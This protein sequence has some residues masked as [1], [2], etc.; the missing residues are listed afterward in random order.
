[1]P[2]LDLV[3]RPRTQTKQANRLHALAASFLFHGLMLALILSLRVLY[4][5]TAPPIK[6]GSMPGAPSITLEKMVVISP[7]PQPPAPMVVTAQSAP[8]PTM[9]ATPHPAISHARL[10]AAQSHPKKAAAPSVSSYAAGPNL[11]PHPPYP[12]EARDRGKT[13]TVIMNVQFNASGDV[14]STEVAQSSGVPLLDSET[15]S[16]IRAHWHSQ[17]YAGQAVSVPVQYSLEKL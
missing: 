14:A 13:G 10:T 9:Q 11:W 17:T 6:S 2:R 4:E 8:Q 3:S 12:E 1:M 7:R 16:Y 5:S 15:R